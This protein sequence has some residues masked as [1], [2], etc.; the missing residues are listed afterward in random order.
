MMAKNNNNYYGVSK[1]RVPGIYTTWSGCNEQVSKFSAECYAGFDTLAECV[2]FMNSKGDAN[3][4]MHVYG[5]RG[6]KYP[7]QDWIKKHGDGRPN[8]EGLSDSQGTESHLYVQLPEEQDKSGQPDVRPKIPPIDVILQPILAYIHYALQGGTVAN[9]KRAVTGYYTEA[10][11]VDA[12]QV[13]FDRCDNV[14]IGSIKHRRDGD[15]RSR[16]DAHVEDIVTAMNMLDKGT[17]MPTFA[18]PSYQI[19]TIPKAHPEELNSISVIERLNKLEEKWCKCHELLDKSVC[20]NILLEDRLNKLENTRPSYAT[21]TH[22]SKPQKYTMPRPAAQPAAQPAVQPATQTAAQSAV[23]P[24]AQ[25]TAQL[26]GPRLQRADLS[27]SKEGSQ[28]IAPGHTKN[29]SN[30]RDGLRPPEQSNRYAGSMDNLSESGASAYQ[31]QNH[32][33]KKLDRQNVRNKR[34]VMGNS[35]SNVASRGFRGAPEPDRHL[36]IYRVEK[37]ASEDDISDYLQGQNISFRSVACLSNP[38][39]KF[40]S[41]RLTVA[42]SNYKQLFDDSLWPQGVRVRSYRPPNVIRYDDV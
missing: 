21:I 37:S 7:L 28:P 38:D 18:I 5:P 17:T 14:V 4:D 23:Q 41:F 27:L 12:K 33:R 26:T 9:V 20:H 11:I 15:N 29:D 39:S 8:K 32:Y 36:F 22:V 25:P 31:Y 34:V 6:G 30:P 2:D 42:V 24:A 1:G 3:D 10:D 35:S 16:V 13:L 19:D 40:K